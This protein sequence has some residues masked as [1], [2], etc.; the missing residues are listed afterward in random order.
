MAN[1]EMIGSCPFFH[2][3]LADMP[4]TAE[5]LKK[6]YC[7]G[8]NSGCARYQVVQSCGPGAMK[9]NLFPH[10]TNRVD[11]IVAEFRAQE[12]CE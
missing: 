12:A 5:R 7:Q 10:E 2:D 11:E 4:K 1:C 9:P 6:R 8:D 3:K